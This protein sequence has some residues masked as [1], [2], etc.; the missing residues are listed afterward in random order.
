MW[1]LTVLGAVLVAV[2]LREVFHTLFH[3][4]GRG[5]VS[6]FV[7]RTVWSAAQRLG[8]RAMALAGP[9]ALI[10]VIALWAGG[11]IVGWALVYWPFMPDG[12]IFASPLDPGNQGSFADA[13]YLSWVTQATLGYGDIAP[14][15]DALRM[16]APLQAT[17]G[18]ALFTAAV[19]W[20]LSIYPALGRRRSLATLIQGFRGAT[21][22][23]EAAGA[24][25][26]RTAL[27]RRL[28]AMTDGV[29]SV[30]VDLAQY[31]ETFYFAPPNESMSLATHLPYAASLS[32]RGDLG[33]EAQTAAAELAIAIEEFAASIGT[34]HLRME[35]A[36]TD[37]VLRGYRRH[38]RSDDAGA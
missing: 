15:E 20:V 10:L 2:V 5:G 34:E 37:E 3:P 7:F 22:R 24:N 16:L 1:A 31:P 17:L 30:R 25:L 32:R 28:H 19:T 11:L 13:V 38:E 23:I 33:D 6:M 29:T 27:A 8:S 36:D 18:F 12:F 9:A 14:Q 21:E 4:G 35:E 26:D